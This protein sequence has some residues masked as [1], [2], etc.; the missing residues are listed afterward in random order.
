MGERRRSYRSEPGGK[1]R[2]TGPGWP[3][4][5]SRW[6]SCRSSSGGTDGRSCHA[7]GLRASSPRE[8]TR[9]RSKVCFLYPVAGREAGGSDVHTVDLLFEKARV[10][11]FARSQQ[12]LAGPTHTTHDT[13]NTHTHTA[14]L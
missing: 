2:R 13:H 10:G 12:E 7:L 4:T 9:G 11:R 5:R 1:C 3:G 8:Q 6:S 14:R